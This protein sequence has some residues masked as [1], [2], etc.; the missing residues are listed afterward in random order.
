M[1]P[2]EYNQNR[3]PVIVGVVTDVTTLSLKPQTHPHFY[4]PVLAIS[5]AKS[6][7]DHARGRDPAAFATVLRREIKAV[8]PNLPWP[9]I[10]TMDNILADVVAQPRFQAWLLTLFGTIALVL[11]AVGL[12]GVLAYAVTQRTHE[13]GIRLALGAQ[14][15]NV[16]SLVIGQGMRLAL[17]GVG[18]GIVVAIGSCGCCARSFTQWRRLIRSRSRR[19]RCSSF[20]LRSWPVGCPRDERRGWIQWRRFVMNDVESLNR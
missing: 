1:G 18:I 3:F 2:G 11:A 5:D 13:I 20:P 17:M 14:K 6:D 19:F 12:Y 7:R 15:R 8:L 9:V 4:S 10:Q 16:L